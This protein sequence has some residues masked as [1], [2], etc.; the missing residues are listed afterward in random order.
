MKKTMISVFTGFPVFVGTSEEVIAAANRSEAGGQVVGFGGSF[1]LVIAVNFGVI[2][3]FT[4]RKGLFDA[5]SAARAEQER[6][7]QGA[8]V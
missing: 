7:R 6:I 3:V 1:A 8:A 4:T 2:G 5:L